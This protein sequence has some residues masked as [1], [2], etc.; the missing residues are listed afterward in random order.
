MT[1]RVQKSIKFKLLRSLALQGFDREGG[2][3]EKENLPGRVT[4]LKYVRGPVV[5]H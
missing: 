5:H 1:E 2:T 3:E 4:I